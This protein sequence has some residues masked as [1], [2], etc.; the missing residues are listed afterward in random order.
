MSTIKPLSN[1][2]SIFY[3]LLWQKIFKIIVHTRYKPDIKI[4]ALIVFITRI[5]FQGEKYY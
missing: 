5:P 4:D 3:D 1:L 2:I